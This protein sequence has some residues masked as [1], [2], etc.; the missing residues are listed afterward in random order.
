VERSEVDHVDSFGLDLNSRSRESESVFVE[1]RLS[2]HVAVGTIE[3]AAGVRYDRYDTFGSEISP[4]LALAL[5]RGNRKWRAAYGRGFRA[6]AIGELYAPFFGNPDLHAERSQN[7]EIGFDQ[8][9]NDAALSV[10]AFRSDYDDLIAFSG[11][12]FGNVSRARSHGIELGVS[13]R[14]GR[15]ATGFSYTWLRA[16]D[17]ADDEQLLRRPEHSGSLS[18]GYD[19]APAYAEIVIIHSSERPDV[20][21]LFPFGRVTSEASTTAD[22]TLHYDLGSLSPFLKI[23]N[24]AD[25]RYDEVFGYPSARRRAIIGVRYTLR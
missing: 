18:L 14:F 20:T 2:A 6:P 4:R 1:D 19:F 3:L 11:T 8:Y 24:A 16:V 23:E 9:I 15:L 13:R 7:V 21:D 5:V 25:E 10:T 12:R 22:V 17:E